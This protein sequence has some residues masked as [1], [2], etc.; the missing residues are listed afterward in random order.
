MHSS[1]CRPLRDFN[2]LDHIVSLQ[3]GPRVDHIDGGLVDGQNILGTSYCRPSGA[4]CYSLA[5][6][7]P[8]L[9]RYNLASNSSHFQAYERTHLR[10]FPNPSYLLPVPLGFHSRLHNGSLFAVR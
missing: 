6:N 2:S 1:R 10:R 9:I 8:C 3:L 4:G 5:V 7:W